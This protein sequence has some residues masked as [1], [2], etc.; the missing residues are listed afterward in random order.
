MFSTYWT[1]L[2]VEPGQMLPEPMS[3][4]FFPF[5]FARPE[6][7]SSSSG[8]PSLPRLD[9]DAPLHWLPLRFRR[10]PEI[11]KFVQIKFYR[12]SCAKK[13]RIHKPHFSPSARSNIDSST[14]CNRIPSTPDTT[15]QSSSVPNRCCSAHD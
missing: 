12:N 7:R 1:C 4:H 13:R 9:H 15:G 11:R 5:Q 3:L 2:A 6:T 8:T 10:I 14:A